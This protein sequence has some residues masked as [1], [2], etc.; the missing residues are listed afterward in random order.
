MNSIPCYFGGSINPVNPSLN[1]IKEEIII[2]EALAKIYINNG[3]GGYSISLAQAAVEVLN[4]LKSSNDKPDL[5]TDKQ[6][7]FFMAPAA[8]LGSIPFAVMADNEKLA[9]LW[10]KHQH[11]IYEQFKIMCLR[12]EEFFFIRSV[13]QEF[14]YKVTF[15]DLPDGYVSLPTSE[16]LKQFLGQE[17]LHGID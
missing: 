17:G 7:L 16:A 12:D 10:L 3:V 2:S 8:I 15:E 14:F 13:Y 11:K 5:I 6:I 4:R 9:R 1:D